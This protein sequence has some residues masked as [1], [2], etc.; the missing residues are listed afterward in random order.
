MHL[1]CDDV[2]DGHADDYG[3]GGDRCDD[4]TDG[5]CCKLAA[6][7]LRLDAHDGSDAVVA[8]I[9]ASTA[10]VA[11]DCLAVGCQHLHTWNRFS[12]L[13]LKESSDSGPDW[14]AVEDMAVVAVGNND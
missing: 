14:H 4:C 2:R 5:H 6:A 7:R 12:F 8:A 10:A 3:H 1:Y 11:I 9:A 13:I